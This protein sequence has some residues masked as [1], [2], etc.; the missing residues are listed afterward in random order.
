MN[1]PNGK[2]SENGPSG[3]E[4]IS[5]GADRNLACSIA[6]LLVPG[7]GQYF[8]ERKFWAIPQFFLF[9]LVCIL[10][11]VCGKWIFV[12]HSLLV[13]FSILDAAFWSEG[14][15]PK[16]LKLIGIVFLQLFLLTIIIVSFIGA[17]IP[18]RETARRMQCQGHSCQL[19]L[20]F[21]NYHD[22]YGSFPPAYTK[23]ENG[24]ILHGWRV[25]ILPFI[26][27]REL[28]EKIRLNEPWDSEYNS[29]FHDIEIR[30]FHARPLRNEG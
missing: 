26:E 27:E 1:I 2:T 12:A 23:D 10:Y 25:L 18:A 22:M 20:A 3:R 16:H 29:Q 19:A 9:V 6:S 30:T 24:K 15:I 5:C 21:H 13:V 14:N 17:A 8:Q 4:N 11:G 7:L 28:Y